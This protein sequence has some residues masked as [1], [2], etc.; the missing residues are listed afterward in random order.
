MAKLAMPPGM[1]AATA[2]GLCHVRN[3]RSTK[4][5]TLQALVLM[6][7]GMAIAS[8]SRQPPSARQR[9]RK[10]WMHPDSTVKLPLMACH[11]RGAVA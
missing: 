10:P 11:G 4:C 8:S 2:S 5:C 7:S 1:A 3:I 6:I 9:R